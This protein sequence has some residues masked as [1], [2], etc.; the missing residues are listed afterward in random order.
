MPF[1]PSFPDIRVE[2]NEEK[3]FDDWGKKSVQACSIII[4]REFLYAVNY[5]ETTRNKN[6][7]P[8]RFMQRL[9]CNH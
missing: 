1:S 2:A 6:L 3:I 8:Q 9:L 5:I 7:H 4:S